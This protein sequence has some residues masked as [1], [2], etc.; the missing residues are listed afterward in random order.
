MR[1]RA[2]TFAVSARVVFE[3]FMSFYTFPAIL[4]LLELLVLLELSARDALPVIPYNHYLKN[5]YWN[6]SRY[7]TATD[8]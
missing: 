4:E 3:L 7:T 6:A 1:I 8:M 2:E 5:L